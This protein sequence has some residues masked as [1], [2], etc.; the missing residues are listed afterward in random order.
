MIF[1]KFKNGVYFYSGFLT[2]AATAREG[3]YKN[4]KRYLFLKAW[5]V[6]I[7]KTFFSLLPTMA[8]TKQTV[9]AK[10]K[11]TKKTRS[12]KSCK[13]KKVPK[14]ST[15]CR[16]PSISSW[17]CCIVR[18]DG[19]RNQQSCGRGSFPY[20]YVFKNNFVRFD[21]IRNQKLLMK[22]Y[23]FLKALYLLFFRTTKLI[24]ESKLKLLQHS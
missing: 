11:R 16:A 14:S 12:S 13:I 17:Y 15:F 5:R 4:M 23:L 18:F 6:I 2:D 24:S 3:N 10:S 19:I 20:R 21:G 7:L 9:R 22:R 8:R 1:V